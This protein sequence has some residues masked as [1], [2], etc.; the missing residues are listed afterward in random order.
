[1]SNYE[2]YEKG[3]AIRREVLGDAHVDRSLGSQDAFD[4]PMIRF[5][6]ESYWAKIWG[7]N[8]LPKRDCSLAVIAMLAAMNR[9]DEL[10]LHLQAAVRN[11]LAVEEIREV[12]L[13]TAVYCGAPTAHSAFSVAKKTFNF[14]N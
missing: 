1:M 5:A 2:E 4:E 12:L 13:L 14:E 10:A 9:P 11:G 8:I 3:L 7:R 6:T